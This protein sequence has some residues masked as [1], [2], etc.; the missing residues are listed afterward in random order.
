MDIRPNIKLKTVLLEKGITQRDLAFSSNI[1][2]SRISKIIK[3]Y[4][5]PT[6]EMKE[7]ISEFLGME[8]EAL[9]PRCL[10]T[11]TR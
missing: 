1:D 7:A 10:D 11:A 6:S 8:Q 3:G 4:E 5:R 2:E 9:F